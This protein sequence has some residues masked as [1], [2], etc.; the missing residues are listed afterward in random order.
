MSQLASA[1]WRVFLELSP[2]AVSRQ[3]E[4]ARRKG[5]LKL[6]SDARDR[7]HQL[8]EITP[9]GTAI[10]AG[11]LAA[12]EQHVFPIF[13]DHDRQASL[14][15]HMNALLGHTKEVITEQSKSE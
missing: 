1:K 2:G 5:W 14:M 13:H 15:E 7:R 6:S 3:V 10:V 11:G 9:A 4:L 12:L 8:L